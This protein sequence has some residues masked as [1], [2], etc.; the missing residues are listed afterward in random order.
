MMKRPIKAVVL[1]QYILRLN[2]LYYGTILNGFFKISLLLDAWILHLG[3]VQQ[4]KYYLCLKILLDLI[5]LFLE[6]NLQ[7][8]LI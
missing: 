6:G 8:L 7:N 5:I 3:I 4:Y 1:H 2:R